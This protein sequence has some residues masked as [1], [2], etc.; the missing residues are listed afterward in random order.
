[1]LKYRIGDWDPIRYLACSDP[2]TKSILVDS[3]DNQCLPQANLEYMCDNRGNCSTQLRCYGSEGGQCYDK[4]GK[5]IGRLDSRLS[6]MDVTE[7]V[8]GAFSMESTVTDEWIAYDHA[9][10]DPSSRLK[11]C[12]MT[13]ETIFNGLINEDDSVSAYFKQRF[14][15]ICE[16]ASADDANKSMA[17]EMDMGTNNDDDYSLENIPETDLLFKI[18]L[19]KCPDD[20]CD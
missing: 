17:T 10:N 14:Q 5:F 9:G 8:D 7:G 11:T 2:S 15:Q 12:N 6:V 4:T 13:N 19:E 3:M 18:L 1:M 20:N 16:T